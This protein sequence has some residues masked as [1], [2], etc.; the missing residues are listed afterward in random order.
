MTQKPVVLITG[1]GRGIGAAT[2][3][4]AASR[5]YAVAIN[6]KSNEAAA[7][8]VVKAIEGDG[9][10]AV[11]IRGD[12]ANEDDVERVFDDV[13]TS[14]GR[15][16]HLVYNSGVTGQNSRFDSVATTTLRDVVD[17]NVMGAFFAARAAIRRM[18]TRHGGGG[19]SMVFL[20]SAVANLG[21]AGEYVWYAASKGAIDS[22]TIGLSRELAQEGI[23]VNAV[24]PGAID[25]D[26]HEPGRLARIAPQLPM[27]RVGSPQEV[28]QAILFLMSD[29]SA[30]TSGTILRVSGAR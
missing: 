23:R 25:T 30:Y 21:A 27:G 9:G 2:A 10:R 15:L 26:I 14:L 5:G 16:R 3:R 22:L 18:S 19:G 17:I 12:M 8:G 24:A 28:A 20:S 13:D 4:L 7:A 1:G 29:A 11:A 6:Y